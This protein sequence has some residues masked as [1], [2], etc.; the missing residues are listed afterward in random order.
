[1]KSEH[2]HQLQTNDLSRL[3]IKIGQFFE[4]YFQQILISCAVIVAVAVGIF[5]YR[6]QDSAEAAAWSALFAATSADQ[7]ANVA[8]EFPGTT[9]GAWAMLNHAENLLQSGIRYSFTDRAA[10][11]SDLN[12]SRERFEELRRK[13]ELPEVVRQRALLGLARCLEATSDGNT[14][15]AVAVY[16]EIV[17]LGD[18]IY[19]EQAQQRIDQLESG[20]AQAFYAWFHK[21]NPQP[22]D[23]SLPRDGLLDL[24]PNDNVELPFNAP[25]TDAVE[26]GASPPPP[27]LPE[28]SET[29]PNIPSAD[30]PATDSNDPSPQ[31]EETAPASNEPTDPEPANDSA[32]EK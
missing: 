23:R 17:N 18:S 32:T 26:D 16:K 10:A 24:L 25:S 20:T 14:S 28:T 1:M 5:L 15:E 21:Q 22:E 27:S 31:I 19:R 12:R 30:R 9:V 8:D 2:R 3:A 7:F 11:V 29:A 4:T 13:T 6:G